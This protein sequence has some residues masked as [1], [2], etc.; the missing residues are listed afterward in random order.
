MPQEC[1][2]TQRDIPSQAMVARTLIATERRGLKDDNRTHGPVRTVHPRTPTRFRSIEFTRLGG[3]LTPRL[4]SDRSAVQQY[5]AGSVDPSHRSTS[6]GGLRQIATCRG[7]GLLR[8]SLFCN[9]LF[10][11]R[12]CCHNLDFKDEIDCC[13][14]HLITWWLLPDTGRAMKKCIAFTNFTSTT[15]LAAFLPQPL[16]TRVLY[17]VIS[18]A[19]ILSWMWFYIFSTDERASLRLGWPRLHRN[20]KRRATC[21][22]HLMVLIMVEGLALRTERLANK[23]NNASFVL[24]AIQPDRH[25]A[26]P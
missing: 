18:C 1:Q 21:L 16:A 5:R 3:P 25:A 8:L 7:L 6:S 4:V 11:V 2:N 17:F 12:G 9:S 26:S 20:L 19:M 23:V 13:A 24:V 15:A 10:R 22:P 14:P